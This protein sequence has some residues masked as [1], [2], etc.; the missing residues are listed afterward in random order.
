M[1]DDATRNEVK[2]HAAEVAQTARE[3]AGQVAG[4]MKEQATQVAD[5]VKAQGRQVVDRTKEQLREQGDTQARQAAQSLR[6]LADEARALA[7]GRPDD[8]GPVADYVRQASERIEGVAQR[9][10]E[11]GAQGMVEDLERFGRRRPGMFLAGAAV[12]GFVAGRLIRGAAAASEDRG[13][14][15]DARTSAMRGM[16]GGP[17]YA[18]ATSVREPDAK[19]PV[20]A[21]ISY[22][23]NG[24]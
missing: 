13:A 17:Q 8:A 6:T 4:T 12:A 23:G 20:P 19:V 16:P 9:V 10:E 2:D 21:A 11:R 7:D 22:T 5:E 3:Q 18:G 1:V 14:A 15:G 24:G